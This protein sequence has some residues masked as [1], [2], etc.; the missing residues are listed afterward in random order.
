MWPSTTDGRPALG[1]HGDR[2]PGVLR[3]VAQVLAHL[4]RAGGAVE[5]DDVGRSGVERGQARRRSRCRQHA[6]GGLHGDLHLDGHLAALGAMARRAPIM[7][8][9]GL[10]QVV[11]GSR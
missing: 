8:A 2:E 1:R 6:P 3:Q 4:G 9:F 7:A 10:E 5:P 11:T